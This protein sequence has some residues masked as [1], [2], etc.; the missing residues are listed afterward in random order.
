[1]IRNYVN[2]MPEKQKIVLV[3]PK[4]NISKG[5]RLPIPILA[6][7]R[8]A[9]PEKYD[10]EIINTTVDED[11]EKKIIEAGKGALCFGISSMTGY[12][13]KSGLEVAHVIKKNFPNTPIIWGG[14][15]PSLFPEH[16]V[17]HPCV[18]IVV[19]GQGERTFE[20]LVD[21]LSAG[22]PIA[23]VRGIAFKSNG[24][25]VQTEERL[26]EDINNFPP[27]PYHLVKDL[28]KYIVKTRYAD[29][30]LAY[31]SSQGCPFECA[32][33]CQPVVCKRRW[34]GLSA[35]NVL[36]ELEL[37]SKNYGV[38]GVSLVDSNFFV[39]KD[40]VKKI[41]EGILERKMKMTFAD[42]NAR[43]EIWKWED[44]MWELMRKAGIRHLF[45]GTESGSQKA[46]DLIGKGVK[47]EDTIKTVEKC[48]KH[49]IDFQLSF[50]LGLPTMD[51]R[52]EME[53]S[54][55]LIDEVIK[56]CAGK[57][58]VNVIFWR[59]APYPGSKLYY[60]S[61]D[62]G[63]KPPTD[64]EGWSEFGLFE[65]GFDTP[66][67]PKKYWKI[68]RY[69]NYIRPYVTGNIRPEELRPHERLPAKIWNAMAKM[70]WKGRFFDFAIDYKILNY[71][72]G[73]KEK[74]MFAQ[75][76]CESE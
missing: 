24:K 72:H 71:Y 25:I 5:R 48:A 32:F 36:K 47:V 50:M 7:A 3:Y 66:W 42:V 46:L 41:C 55:D 33:C 17:A 57:I 10:V 51:V 43:V 31:L 12:Q 23:D 11:Y 45:I 20:E 70:R 2:Q 38:D 35:E 68:V 64:F 29:R 53:K 65:E 13:I 75:T 28:E 39:S 8:M 69:L 6:I 58:D 56:I 67:V 76:T 22:K 18:D 30:S 74:G 19:F 60:L 59:Y 54:L 34:V 62:S 15:H 4:P 44:E 52:E 61:I 49:G 40:R 1:M 9:N 37:L 73:L 14:Y 26:Y 16:T 63:F 21:R 27:T